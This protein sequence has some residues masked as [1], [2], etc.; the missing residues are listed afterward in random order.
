MFDVYLNI[1]Q[2]CM[3]HEFCNETWPTNLP[4]ISWTKWLSITLSFM[5][6]GHACVQLFKVLV[7]SWITRDF[8]PAISAVHVF[9]RGSIF[10]FL[11]HKLHLRPTDVYIFHWFWHWFFFLIIVTFYSFRGKIKQNTQISAAFWAEHE[12]W[13]PKVLLTK[14]FKIHPKFWGIFPTL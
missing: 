8:S 13:K 7:S 1:W 5:S 12:G 2:F 10:R 3:W 6:E 4:Y 11:N 14:Q 9:W